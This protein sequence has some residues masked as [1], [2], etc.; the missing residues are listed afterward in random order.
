M[1][2]FFFDLILLFFYLEHVNHVLS[3]VPP[4]AFIRS[5]R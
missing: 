1:L 5:L 4:I 2:R 3:E